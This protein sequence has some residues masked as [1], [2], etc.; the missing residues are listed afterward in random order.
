MERQILLDLCPSFTIKAETSQGVVSLYTT[1]TLLL[2]LCPVPELHGTIQPEAL[3]LIEFL[4]FIITQA[5]TDYFF[6]THL[7]LP[8][9][10]PALLDFQPPIKTVGL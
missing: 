3:S 7:D 9:Q 5:M 4:V 10:N 1:P 2:S 6:S 8:G